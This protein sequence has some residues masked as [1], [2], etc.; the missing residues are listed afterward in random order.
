MRNL[1]FLALL[2]TRLYMQQN[3]IYLSIFGRYCVLAVT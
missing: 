2:A 1:F 3:Y